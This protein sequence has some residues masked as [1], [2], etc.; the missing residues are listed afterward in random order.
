MYLIKI[1][2]EFKSL[3]DLRAIIEA[4]Q[5]FES[6]INGKKKIFETT[7]D[8]SKY[9]KDK[10]QNNRVNSY[11]SLY[12]VYK[13]NTQK[14]FTIY[15]SIT[16]DWSYEAKLRNYQS[17]IS[18][19]NIAN[20][21]D[22]ETVDTLLDICQ[23]NKDIFNRFFKLKQKELSLK[24]MTRYDIY[25]PIGAK[26]KKVTYDNAVKLVLEVLKGFDSEIYSMASKLFNEKNIDVYPIKNKRSGAFCANVTNRFDPFLLLN[27]TNTT[28]DIFVLAH[29]LGHAIHYMY[30]QE[31]SVLT[32]DAP[33]TLAETASTFTEN[34]VFD[35]LFKLETNKEVKKALLF[36]KISDAYATISR[37]AYFV[38]F[39]K[40]SP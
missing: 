33:L 27:Y 16:K 24:E 1:L 12:E 34:I 38:I 32:Q 19:R 30:S 40:R 22:D 17:N 36:D 15:Q 23:K 18:I 39:E 2:M 4:D 25:A 14:Y 21:I 20:D 28:R 8:I 3:L 35:Y 11:N 6:I 9:F 26:E 7:S 31:Q 10:D 29:E 13:H 37:Q 5:K